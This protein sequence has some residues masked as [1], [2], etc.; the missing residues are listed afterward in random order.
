MDD[1]TQVSRTVPVPADRLFALL[2]DPA[3]HIEFDTS[4]MVRGLASGTVAGAVGDQ[5][6]MA[7]H[8]ERLGDH[9][10]RNTVVAFE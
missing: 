9:R 1:R 7:M 5:F 8:N 3:R 10:M 2:A 6:V 4:G